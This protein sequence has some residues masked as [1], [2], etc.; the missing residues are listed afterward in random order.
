VTAPADP[1][2]WLVRGARVVVDD[3]RFSYDG[4]SG[5]VLS[6]ARYST[7]VRLDAGE[8]VEVGL[9][10]LRPEDRPRDEP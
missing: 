2:A 6:R 3:S 9:D 8:D 1:F 10:R 4:E 7:L 5:V